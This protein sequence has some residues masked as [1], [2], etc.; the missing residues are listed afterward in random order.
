MHKMR[1]ISL[2]GSAGHIVCY[3]LMRYAGSAA[4]PI[5]KLRKIRV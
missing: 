1:T 5:W 4:A 3:R 2:A